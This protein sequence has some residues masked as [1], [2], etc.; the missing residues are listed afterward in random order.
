MTKPKYEIGDRVKYYGKKAEI[1]HVDYLELAQRCLYKI[2]IRDEHFSIVVDESEL[3]GCWH[4]PQAI[5]E[6]YDD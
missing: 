3:S 4:I 6:F 2:R 1:L 5:R